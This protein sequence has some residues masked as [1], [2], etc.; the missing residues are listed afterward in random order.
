MENQT[1]SRSTKKADRYPVAV[2]DYERIINVPIKEVS[3]MS[4]PVME[5]DWIPDWR[6]EL[7]HCP[8]GIAEDG[9]NFYEIGTAPFLGDSISQKCEWTAVLREPENDR[10]HWR[11]ENAISTTL[12][13]VQ[14]D[15]LGNGKTKARWQMTYTPLNKRGAKV[16]KKGGAEKIRFMLEVLTL[17]L[18]RY[19][20][21]GKQIE[22]AEVEKLIKETPVLSGKDKIRMALNGIIAKK[23]NDPNRS[24]YLNGLP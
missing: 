22:A 1:M 2:V 5:Y 8:N 14:F 23:Q 10:I 15:N 12:F 6:C 9:T 3:S 24:R 16:L 17:M 11:L 13:K 18:K 7:L 4:C 19:V 21:T 20:E